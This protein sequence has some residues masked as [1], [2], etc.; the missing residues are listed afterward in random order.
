MG[1]TDLE[2]KIRMVDS[3]EAGKG[4]PGK[5][6][7]GT[8]EGDGHVLCLERGLGCTRICFYLSS[9][10]ETHEICVFHCYVHFTTKEK[11]HKQ[12]LKPS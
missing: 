12:I 8:F 10:D 2:K 3:R 11:T 1:K 5:R 7:E 6:H 9:S 4:L